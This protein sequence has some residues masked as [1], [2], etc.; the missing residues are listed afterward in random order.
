MAHK[1]I[2][3]KKQFFIEITSLMS[4]SSNVKLLPDWLQFR[5]FKTL[6]A[7]FKATQLSSSFE[8]H[9]KGMDGHLG[10]INFT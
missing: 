7:L 8:G 3:E 4:L 1:K 2:Q 9:L 5:G 10:F 6:M